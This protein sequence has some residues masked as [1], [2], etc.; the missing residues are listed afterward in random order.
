MENLKLDADVLL[1]IGF[2][3]IGRW[4]PKGDAITYQLD[5][6]NASTNEALLDSKNALYAFEKGDDVTIRQPAQSGNATSAIAA[7]GRGRRRTS[8]ATTT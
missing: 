2:V 1:N 5:G 4:M 6:E 3:D 8:A 7:R